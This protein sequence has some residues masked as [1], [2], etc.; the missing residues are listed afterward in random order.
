MIKNYFIIAY[1]NLLRHKGY[2][3]I[4]VSGLAVGLACCLLIAL[5]VKD[6]LSYDR[7]NENYNEIYRVIHSYRPNVDI[8]KT[9]ALPSEYQVWGNAPVGP[10]LAADFP[11]VLKV[12]QF[13]GRGEFL[14]QNGEKRF[15]EKNVFFVD[16]TVFDVFSWKLLKGNPD[17]A[18]AAPLSVV[19]TESTAK[20][21]FGEADPIGQTLTIDNNG[22]FMVTGVMED[23]P[24]NSHFTF[25]ALFSMN[26]FRKFRPE[27]FTYYGYVDFYTYFRT[28]KGYDINELKAKVPDFLKRHVD[29]REFY[30]FSFEP[31][32]DA[33]LRSAAQRQPGTTGSL[34]N[35]YIFSIIAVFILVIACINFMN[36]STARSMD[37]AKEVGVRKSVG[38]KQSGLIRQFLTE[39]VLLALLSMIFAL[40]LSGIA[41]PAFRELS[42]K[43]ILVE[44]LYSTEVL[45]SVVGV[46]VVTGLLAGIYPSIVLS[47]FRPS[48]VL[49]GKFRNSSEGVFLRKGLVVFQFTL[50]TALITGTTVVFLQVR[51][52]QNKTTG[53]VKDQMVVIDFGGD[54]KVQEKIESIK[55]TLKQVPGVVSASNQRTVPGGFFPQAGSQIE[56][57]DGE[58]KFQNINLYEVDYDFI[59]NYGIEV[60]AGRDY[61]RASADT[62]HSLIINEA[63]ARFNGYSNPQDIIGKKFSQWGREGVVIGVVKDFNYRS[64]HHAIDPI[65]LRLEP[66]YSSNTIAVRL[67]T[68]NLGETLSSLE[69]TW[70]QVAPQRPFLYSFQNESFNDQYQSDQRF[71]RVFSAF[72]VFAI[73]VACLGLFGLVTFTTEQRA[74]EI[75]IR[76]VLGATAGNIVVLLSNDFIKLIMASILLAIPLSWYPLNRWLETF[77]YRIDIGAEVFVFSGLALIIIASLVVSW[78]SIKSALANP[79]N[80]LRSE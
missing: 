14:F 25:D 16:S 29:P 78:Q 79:V 23:V 68:S 32:S 63:A 59:S 19:L 41:L 5:F 58:M 17:K 75:G 46:S 39:T 55:N 66:Q 73:F 27:I 21:Y 61:S 26:T 7:Y 47:A 49:K 20:R 54:G 65:S 2:T 22:E 33:Y 4:N 13:S 60:V 52:L 36:L 15:K 12:T 77:A 42:G 43:P 37:R 34:N 74:K 67:N 18:L 11:E 30:T 38:A 40:T 31:L 80:A 10:D 57:T 48:Q 62:A 28:P 35:V 50:S 64:L 70:R 3:F 69:Q 45:L 24:S 56:Q 9:P 71:G 51:H 53:F 72:A 76:K 6:E 1:R 8:T 44:T